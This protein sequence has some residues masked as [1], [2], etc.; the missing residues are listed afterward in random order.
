MRK[1]TLPTKAA[2]IVKEKIGYWYITWNCPDIQRARFGLNR[3]KDLNLRQLWAERIV[4]FINKTIKNDG[5]FLDTDDLPSD[6]Q[7]PVFDTRPAFINENTVLN[8]LKVFIKQKNT[9]GVSDTWA[10]KW[11]T[12]RNS[13]ANYAD[14]VGKIDFEFC[15]L[16]KDW[17]I[18]YKAWRYAPP[19]NHSINTV[20]KDF[21]MLRQLIKEAEIED[22]LPVEKA[23]RS[24]AYKVGRI[25]TDMVAMSVAQLNKLL[26]IEGLEPYLE[27]VRDNYVI[28][29]YTAL[30]WGNW[31]IS[32]HNIIDMKNG[33]TVQTMLK[34]PLSVKTNDVIYIPLHPVAKKILEKYDY[35]L[36]V[37]SNQNSNKYIKLIAQ[38]AA[39]NENVS[40]KKSKGGK[41]VQQTKPFYKWVTT[42]TARRTFVTIGLYELKIPAALLMKIT[43]HKTEK[44]LFE[45]A[46]ITSQAAAFELSKYF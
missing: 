36:P 40:L 34:L 6:I 45:Y 18:A 46:R 26:A 23:Y 5:V 7:P 42:H 33:D 37:I 30:R 14:E 24:K 32:K 15:D 12:L 35:E 1:L 13:I 3:I 43:G 44:Q 39:L 8:Y 31:S 17:A 9:E 2:R 20:A 10:K 41:I 22:N 25:L 21:S 28:A 11:V 4:L 29:C 16:T 27:R 19:R 38:K